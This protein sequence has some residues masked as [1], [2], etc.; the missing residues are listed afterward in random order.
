MVEFALVAPVFFLLIVTCIEFCRLNM[1]RNLAQ[2]AAYYAARR[3][4]VPGATKSEIESMVNRTLSSLGTRGA[5]ISV[6]NG[7][8]LNDSS[9][10]VTVEVRI[11]IGSNALI[12][13]NFTREI[14]F[15]A[16]S[17]IRTERQ[18]PA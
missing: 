16:I 12:M 4:M 10:T 3:C 6:N 7:S 11:P 13:P 9:P 18:N 8:S 14:E 15:R 17:T 2:D 1:I 5:T